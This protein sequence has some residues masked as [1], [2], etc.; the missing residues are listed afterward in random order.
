MHLSKVRKHDFWRHS[1]AAERLFAL[2]GEREAICMQAAKHLDQLLDSAEEAA[3]VRSAV[4]RRLHDD[5]EKVVTAILSGAAIQTL[6]ASE[7]AAEIDALLK[8]SRSVYMSTSES[9]TTRKASRSIIRQVKLFYDW[10][11]SGR[12]CFAVNTARPQE[13]RFA[14]T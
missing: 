4:V 8:K 13:G 12:G 7:L 3:F 6:P 1:V 2:H 9:K 14:A 5:E 11:A 10:S